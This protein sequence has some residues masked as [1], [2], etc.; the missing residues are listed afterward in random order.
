MNRVR[1]IKWSVVL[2]I[3]AVGAIQLVPVDR[4]NPE[5]ET[6]IATSSNVHS[7][8]RRACYNCHSN[9]TEWPWYSRVAPISWLVA[10]DVHEGRDNMNF[11]TWNRLTLNEQSVAIRRCWKKVEEREMPPWFYLLPHPEARLSTDD[12]SV[13]RDWAMAVDRN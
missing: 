13:L 12:L 6:E 3:L 8:L 11:S 1:R 10:R 9:E 7:V 4:T 2:L 5:V